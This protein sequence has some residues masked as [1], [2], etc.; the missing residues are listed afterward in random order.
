MTK[1]TERAP[2]TVEQPD[3]KRLA[4]LNVSNWPIWTKDPS[5]FAWHYDEPEMCYFLEGDVIVKTNHGEVTVGPG[6][7]VTFP[8]GLDCTWQVRRRV[9]KHYR[10]G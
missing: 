1:A 2:I 8:S 7:L 10:L 6:D 4:E 5:T 9:R 3:K